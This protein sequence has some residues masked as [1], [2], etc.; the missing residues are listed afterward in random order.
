M[1]EDALR[2][3]RQVADRAA[4]S[5]SRVVA[6]DAVYNALDEPKIHLLHVRSDGF[7]LQHARRC[8][9]TE[10]DVAKAVRTCLLIS[11]PHAVGHTYEV[12]LEDEGALRFQ[13]V[14]KS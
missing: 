4:A 6:L 5:G 7:N 2:A 1:S 12:W 3:V 14:T 10:C 13:E 9:G 8:R 11:S